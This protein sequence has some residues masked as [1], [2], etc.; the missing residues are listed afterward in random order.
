MALAGLWISK[1]AP[2]LIFSPFIG[3]LVDRIDRKK[4]M[5]I[6]DITRGLLVALLPLASVFG[7]LI[8]VYIIIFLSEMF[9]LFFVP[10]KDASIPDLVKKE[11]LIDANS[12]SFTI[13]QVT[14]LLGLGVGTTIILLVNRVIMV[15][16]FL[17]GLAGT[18]TAVYIDA[19][20]FF[21]SAAIM[22]FIHLPKKKKEKHEYPSIIE[23]VK[24]TF[25]FIAANPKIKSIIIS[26]GFS[27]LGLG[28]ILIVG[29]QYTQET[30]KMGKDGF[31][32]LLTLLAVGL[33][34]GAISSS[35][36]SHIISKESLFSSSLSIVGLSL[37]AFAVFP[38]ITVAIILS[39]IS[40]FA[41]GILYVTAYTIFH[42]QVSDLIRGRLFA[43][44]EADLRLAL[45]I[46]FLVTSGVAS[47]VG[48]K[49]VEILG[50]TFF[51]R[52]SEIVMFGGGVIV[53]IASLY[54]FRETREITKEVIIEK[55]RGR[56]KKK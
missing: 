44:L 41:L 14:M 12:L 37:I 9:T 31:L 33:V 39:V 22:G 45:I 21:L 32:I 6:S 47:L 10:A 4:G 55:I 11:Q 42:E 19:F 30:L 38:S 40:G 13:N 34:I 36:L 46:S 2:S 53:F 35:W 49:T 29:P 16:P 28:T 3:A 26:A 1:I 17:G 52:S 50:Y 51:L 20:T 5:I 18:F 54:A 8:F 25:R 7:G 27:V 56:K 23:E 43:A 48:D 15:I 24:D